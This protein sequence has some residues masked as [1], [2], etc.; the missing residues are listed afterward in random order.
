MDIKKHALQAVSQ[1]K[2]LIMIDQEALPIR[3]HGLIEQGP[4]QQ[5][6]HWLQE[7]LYD[8]NNIVVIMSDMDRNQV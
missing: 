8:K 5:I 2:N 7:I 6:I 3:K 1:R 4:K